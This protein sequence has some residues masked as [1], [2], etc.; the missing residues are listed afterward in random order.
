M[1]SKSTPVLVA[2]TSSSDLVS[3]HEHN[4]AYYYGNLILA[5]QL[6]LVCK[7][8]KKDTSN[9][10]VDITLSPIL[11]MNTLP[12]GVTTDSMA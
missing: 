2:C 4:E 7:A 1:A 6:L 8:E 11:V 9:V 5:D 12:S 10:L 3:E